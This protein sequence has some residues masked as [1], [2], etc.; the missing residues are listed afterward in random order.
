MIT[1]CFLDCE[2]T[3]LN[4]QLHGIIQIAGVIFNDSRSQEFN[5]SCKPFPGDIIDQSALE[6]NGILK[7]TIQ[8]YQDPV[9]VLHQIRT[10]FRSFVDPYNKTEKI[11]LYGYNVRFDED[12]LRLWWK[13][14][15]D[16]YYGSYFWFPPHCVMN[17]AAEHLKDSRHKM[18][19]FKLNT[20]ATQLGIEFKEDSLHDAMV[21]IRLTFEIYKKI[22]GI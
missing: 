3:G 19:N 6:V 5:F 12:F 10:I 7:E 2:T 13:K 9:F 16:N 1:R 8:S 21:D 14:C 22:T 18:P 20:V 17:M 11:F 4:P 15:G